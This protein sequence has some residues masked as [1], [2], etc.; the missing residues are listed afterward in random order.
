V[1]IPY[2]RTDQTERLDSLEP[3]AP[4]S[5][6]AWPLD[7]VRMVTIR[8]VPQGLPHSVPGRE[9]DMDLLVARDAAV[10]LLLAALLT[11]SILVLRMTRR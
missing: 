9:P 3:R 7:M 5:S 4:A 2:Q 11:L 10:M 6:A 1:S 8:P